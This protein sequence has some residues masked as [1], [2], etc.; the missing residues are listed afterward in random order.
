MQRQS[1]ST[2]YS[3]R[4]K[5]LP[6]ELANYR[7]DDPRRPRE[8]IIPRGWRDKI[9]SALKKSALIR[10][11]FVNRSPSR[12]WRPSE[13]GS[14]VQSGKPSPLAPMV[15]AFV[16]IR[17]CLVAGAVLPRSSHRF[18]L[19]MPLGQA[20]LG[21]TCA[22]RGTSRVGPPDHPPLKKKRPPAPGRAEAAEAT[23]SPTPVAS[24]ARMA[25][26]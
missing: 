23:W 18:D 12:S 25:T 17:S 20:W 22:V 13:E 21:P 15:A 5:V 3:R 2:Q 6:T 4:D 7:S 16:C 10:Y 24:P 14:R 1:A 9:G 26:N 8:Q 11:A 19:A